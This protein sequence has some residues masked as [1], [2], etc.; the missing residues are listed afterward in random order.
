[1]EG[2]IPAVTI[3]EPPCQPARNQAWIR[4]VVPFVAGDCEIAGAVLLV[5]D[6]ACGV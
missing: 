1:M 2:I 3:V 5:A 6:V 4:S